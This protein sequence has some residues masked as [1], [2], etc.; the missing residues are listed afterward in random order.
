M[1]LTAFERVAGFFSPGYAAKRAYQR[2]QLELVRK[3]DGASRKPRNKNWKAPI[4]SKNEEIKGASTVLVGRSRD[5]YNN[6]P[7]A[8]RA[9]DSITTNVIGK[10]IKVDFEDKV[11][12]DL[13]KPWAKKCDYHGR[14][15]FYSIQNIA[16]RTIAR[17]GEVIIRRRRRKSQDGLPLPVQLQLIE[18]EFLAMDLNEDLSSGNRIVMG[19]EFSPSGKRVAYHFYKEYPGSTFKNETFRVM[20]KDIIHRFD[21]ERINQ[22]RGIPWLHAVMQRLRDFD[23][24]ED[25]QLLKMKL[26]TCFMAFIKKADAEES[27]LMIQA[28]TD[29]ES[30]YNLEPGSM[31]ELKPGEDVVFPNLPGVDGLTDYNK[32]TLHAIAAG[33]NINYFQ[34]TNDLSQVNYSSIRAGWLEFQR[35]VDS[36]REH[37]IFPLIEDILEWAFEASELTG[38]RGSRKFSLTSPRREMIDPT[39]EIPALKDAIRAGVYSWSE[40][41][42]SLGNDPEDKAM[43]IHKDFERFDK[44]DLI[45]DS[46]PKKTAK[47]GAHQKEE[48]ENE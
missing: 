3:Y 28:E 8:K 19:I 30:D 32:N 48:N 9:I 29:E 25:A 47:N 6:N 26:S 42:R 35:S 4:I 34:L 23:D 27:T 24:W 18:P 41:Q 2:N 45:L 10:G 40:V 46:D 1:K 36:W 20:A 13:F 5:L 31:Q 44:L 21:P 17:D 11:M 15:N 39:K 33:L 37:I 43:E 38:F 22:A 12:E 7:Y 16:M 14:L